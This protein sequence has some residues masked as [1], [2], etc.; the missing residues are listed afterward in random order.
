M[1]RPFKTTVKF[2]TDDAQ[3]IRLEYLV[4]AKSSTEAK[5][6]LERRLLGQEVFGYI[7][8]KVVAATKQEAAFFKAAI[9]LCSVIGLVALSRDGEWF[10][11]KELS[12][13]PRLPL[14][15]RGSDDR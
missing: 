1:Y 2:A 5:S 6:E 13:L 10:W 8:E 3:E 9:R 12:V 15:E 7:V 14:R 4:S 11:S